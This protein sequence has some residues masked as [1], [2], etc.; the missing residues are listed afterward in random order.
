[1]QDRFSDIL[2]A[3]MVRLN[4]PGCG[5]AR[6]A[7][8]PP[9]LISGLRQG[10]RRVGEAN[11]RQIGAALELQGDELEEFVLMAIDTSTR[12]VM[13]Q[14]QGYPSALL[15]LVASQ[16]RRAGVLPD[17]V[18]DYSITGEQNDRVILLLNDGRKAKIEAT[19]TIA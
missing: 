17:L 18:M 14:A 5:V 2:N 3:H 9:S 7:G 11:A 6:R 12:K 4:L 16:L 10:K 15:N 8:V 13:K 19:L 1:M